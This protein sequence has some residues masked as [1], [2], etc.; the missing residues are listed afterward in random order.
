MPPTA[1]TLHGYTSFL[2][3]AAIRGAGFDAAAAVLANLTSREPGA[4]RNEMYSCRTEVKVFCKKM[5]LQVDIYIV[6][7]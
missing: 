7:T 1:S 5:R 2:L 4:V 3:T 6:S